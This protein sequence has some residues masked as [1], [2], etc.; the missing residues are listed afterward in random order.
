[1]QESEPGAAQEALHERCRT[2]LETFAL[3]YFPHY[4]RAVFN[5]YHRD[6]FEEFRPGIRGTRDAHAAPRGSAKSTLEAL[7]R[8]IHDVC[9][10]L[11]KFIV[12][13]SATKSQTA[14]KLK[15]I[16]TEILTNELLI[17]HYGV[18]FSSKRPGET[19]FEVCCGA[20]KVMFMGFSRGS[21]LRGIRYGAFRPTKII[22]DDVED[23]EEVENEEIREKDFAWYFDVVSKVGDKETNI[24]F[25]GTILH[26]QS[27]LARLLKNPAYTGRKYK[28]IISWSERE[29]LW[30]KWRDLYT[31]LDDDDRKA[32]AH[33]F[34]EENEAQ[35]LKGTE[36]LW[37]ENE[38]YE[39][40]MR[41]M[42]EIGRRSFFKEKQNQPLGSKDRIFEEIHWYNE[43][44]DGLV[45]E[46]T[47]ALIP[48]KALHGT[49]MGV[50]DPATGTQK[51]GKRLGDYTC[52]PVG[53]QDPKGRL[54]VHYDWTKRK[55][56]TKYIQEIFELHDRFDFQKFGV[57][58]NLYRE[59]L[60]PNLI[61]E[62]RRREDLRKKTIRI[63]FYDIENTQKKEKRIE[64]IEPK[65]SH[66]WI[67]FNRVLSQE[68]MSQ[69][70]D[71]PADHD[72][73]PDAVEMLWNLVNNAYAPSA[74]SLDAFG[75]R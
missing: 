50:I 14:Q 37:P 15:D 74:L 22:C 11:E 3:V 42:V 40:L 38:P 64:M 53:Y 31:N 32:K 59:L 51:K 23:S 69:I 4:C 45:V 73:A 75:A 61:S 29:D 25:I 34:Y 28:S 16:R 21:E 19:Q 54:L 46:K 26:R 52:I 5:G 71:F 72:D 62:R 60:M 57:E 2:D 12:I 30:D 49:C 9:Y 70:E 20:D 18:S 27:L 33:S 43:T 58:T 35:L 65:V 41:E 36:V 55:S 39:F 10:G 44:A 56:P 63:P 47:G 67:L 7:V 68:F 6:T 66:G 48:W 24:K 1:M 8:P 13:L 17:A